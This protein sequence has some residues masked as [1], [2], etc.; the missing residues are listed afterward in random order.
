LP[1]ATSEGAPYWSSEEGILERLGLLADDV[2]YGTFNSSVKIFATRFGITDFTI[3][4]GQGIHTC[5]WC[6]DHDGA[7]FHRGQFMPELP[8]H[9]FCIHF[10][11]IERVGAKP[12]IVAGTGEMST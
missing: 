4:G 10:Y 6:L 12:L 1:E 11:D 8:K 3:A 7:T 9:P 2:Q 5:A